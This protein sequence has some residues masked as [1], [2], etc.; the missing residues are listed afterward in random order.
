MLRKLFVV[1]LI[2]AVV[3]LVP[4]QKAVA[5]EYSRITMSGVTSASSSNSA[6]FY[7]AKIMGI[8]VRN[9]AGAAVTNTIT[10][11]QITT[12][13]QTN[14]IAALTT[15]TTAS[16]NVEDR[17]FVQLRNDVLAVSATSNFTAEVTLDNRSR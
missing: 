13:G 16:T 9:T 2:G 3:A 1:S 4:C 17:A 14:A 10:V 7:N 12:E 5:A 6:A 11:S 15:D 8:R